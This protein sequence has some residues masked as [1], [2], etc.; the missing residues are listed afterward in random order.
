MWV[1]RSS[2]IAFEW[3]ISLGSLLIASSNV[4]AIGLVAWRLSLR[5]TMMER[6]VNLMFAWFLRQ[7]SGKTDT[8]TTDEMRQFFGVETKP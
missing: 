8:L 3:T 5:F 4:I 1:E 6:K 2:V 7:I